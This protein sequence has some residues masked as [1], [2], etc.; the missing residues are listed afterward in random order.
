MAAGNARVNVLTGHIQTVL[1]DCP[2]DV[3]AVTIGF[4]HHL[5]DCPDAG[6]GLHRPQT[7]DRVVAEGVGL[8]CVALGRQTKPGS[9]IT[10]MCTRWLCQGPKGRLCP[11]PRR[12]GRGSLTYGGLQ[13]NLSRS[14]AFCRSKFGCLSLREST[15]R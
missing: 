10:N 14:W 7:E 11:R 15:Y 8:G 2:A 9:P 12:F 6:V 13:G 1:L 5:R 4:L 3:A